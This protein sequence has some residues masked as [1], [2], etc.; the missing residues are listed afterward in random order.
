VKRSSILILA[1]VAMFVV[2]CSG[3]QA[4][5]SATSSPV[6]SATEEET[7]EAEETPDGGAEATLQ[8][9]AGDLAGLLPTEVGGITIEYESSS[10]DA[11]MG[12]EGVTPEAQEFFDRVGAEPS[13]LSSAFG[14]GVDTETGSGISIIAFRVAGAN[15]GQLR[16][17][18]RATIEEDE[19]QTLTEETV[20]G[21]NVLAI[22]SDGT[23]VS[24]Y[25]YVKN[26]V[27]F[28]VGGSPVEL[29]EEALSQLP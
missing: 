3:D 1:L 13:D 28:V 22:S 23:E 8:P 6:A 25:V 27:V 5:A 19:T 15:E 7:P 29:A 14:F 11:V 26:D 24:G 20:A 9:G 4:G 10:G 12:A 17:E 2:A 21:K 16:D 18:F